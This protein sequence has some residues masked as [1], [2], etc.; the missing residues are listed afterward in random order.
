MDAIDVLRLRVVSNFSN[1]DCG[2]G[3]IHMRATRG[4]R[5]LEISR[6]RACISP[7]PQ[8]PSP[9]PKLETTHSLKC[10]LVHA[11]VHL[12]IYIQYF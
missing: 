1:G 8:S 11:F 2:A 4:E 5:L 12:Y 10:T 6:A 9:S 7:A 3:E